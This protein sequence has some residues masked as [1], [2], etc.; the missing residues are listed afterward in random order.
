MQKNN[1]ISPF[2][3]YRLGYLDGYEGNP[4]QMYKDSDY[5][6]GYEAGKEDDS[7]GASNRFSED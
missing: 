3:R 4:V 7:I 1:E 2:S 6:L 5:I